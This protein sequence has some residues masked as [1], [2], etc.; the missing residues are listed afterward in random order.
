ME[1]NK[2]S[3]ANKTPRADGWT[4]DR[5]RIFLDTLAACGVVN[6]A[7]RAAGMSRQSAY[8]LRNSAC[9]RSFDVA[10]RAA[11]LLARRCM[12]DEV[13]SRALNGCVEVIIR[14]GKVWGERHRFD[15]RLT[16][17][18][19]ARLDQQAASTHQLDDAP[20]R[21]AHEFEAFVDAVC[22]GDA[23]AADFVRTRKG[24][25]HA[26]FGEA[27]II[28][29]NAEY[30]QGTPAE[31]DSAKE[32]S[33]SSTSLDFEVGPLVR[34]PADADGDSTERSPVEP[35]FAALDEVPDDGAMRGQEQGDSGGWQPSISIISPD[36]IPVYHAGHGGP[37][38]RPA[39]VQPHRAPMARYAQSARSAQSAPS[40]RSAQSASIARNW[41]PH[42]PM[43]GGDGAPY[44]SPE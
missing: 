26:A 33:I 39:A 31:D 16:M 44:R 4:P 37:D 34:D 3:F 29:R 42:N 21:V 5:I 24:L 25:P 28:V 32:P 30:L 9:G 36:A 38:V 7:A 1:Q 35:V 27:E 12:A 41:M 43:P 22:Q 15:N 19:L 40:A 20:R 13:M 18:V 23:A 8:V 6:D 11:L 2:I 17:A 10:W 14:D